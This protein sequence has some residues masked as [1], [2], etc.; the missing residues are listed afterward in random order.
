VLGGS[1]TLLSQGGA[2]SDGGVVAGLSWAEL[3]ARGTGTMAEGVL[4]LI[5][6]LVCPHSHSVSAYLEAINICM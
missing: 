6:V 2:R 5:L 3:L 1:S 4:I